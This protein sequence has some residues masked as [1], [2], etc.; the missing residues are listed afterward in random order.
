MMRREDDDDE[1]EEEEEKMTKLRQS[2]CF[3]GIRMSID[4]T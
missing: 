1:E 3:F 4:Y 2:T